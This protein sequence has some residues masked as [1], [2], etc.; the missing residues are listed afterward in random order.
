MKYTGPAYKIG[1]IIPG[2]PGKQKP[3]EWTP[4]QIA[5]FKEKD[6]KRYALWFTEEGSAKQKTGKNAPKT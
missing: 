1:I 2:I 3:A 6:P 5:A 4:E